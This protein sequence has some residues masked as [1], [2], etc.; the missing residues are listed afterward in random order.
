MFSVCIAICGSNKGDDEFLDS[1]E[2]LCRHVSGKK[3]DD[4]SATDAS[5]LG[6]VS[7]TYFFDL[8]R[9]IEGYLGGSAVAIAIAVDVEHSHVARNK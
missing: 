2:Q 8:L 4:A 3:R 9:T 6:T 7:Q 5:K 1:V